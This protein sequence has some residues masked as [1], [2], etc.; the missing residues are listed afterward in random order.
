MDSSVH[1]KYINQKDLTFKKRPQDIRNDATTNQLKIL[2]KKIQLF[3]L[4][5]GWKMK[6]K[7]N[8]G[9]IQSRGKNYFI[10]YMQHAC[11]ETYLKVNVAVCTINGSF[12][13]PFLG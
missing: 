7:L 13:L 9:W 5:I 11:L 8:S 6:V 2:N 12:N 1:I 3:S 10:T 4:E